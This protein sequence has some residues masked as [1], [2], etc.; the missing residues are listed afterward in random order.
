MDPS[1]YWLPSQLLVLVFALL[2]DLYKQIIHQF[3]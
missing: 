2:Y 1:L 3:Y